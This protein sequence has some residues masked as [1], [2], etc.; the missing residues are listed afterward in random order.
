MLIKGSC[1]PSKLCTVDYYELQTTTLWQYDLPIS[2]VINKNIIIYQ[3]CL[4]LASFFELLN[5]N[6]VNVIIFIS[7]SLEERNFQSNRE[8]W[9]Y[10][11][12]SNCQSTKVNNLSMAC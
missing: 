12:L 6:I 10:I 9:W 5:N 7:L 1:H 3:T 11:A 2:N 4:C 8:R